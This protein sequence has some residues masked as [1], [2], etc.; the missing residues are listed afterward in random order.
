MQ[1]SVA[2]SQASQ[3]LIPG[4]KVSTFGCV[5]VLLSTNTCFIFSWISDCNFFLMGSWIWG[6]K[7]FV[8]FRGVLS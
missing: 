7:D 3:A 5:I 4:L 1:E 6:V 2:Q 8:S